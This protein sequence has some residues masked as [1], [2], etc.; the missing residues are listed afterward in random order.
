VKIKLIAVAVAGILLS[1]CNDDNGEV[2]GLSV[3]AFDPAI[4]NMTAKAECDGAPTETSITGYN[5]HAKF[6]TSAPLYAPG[7]CKFT[8]TGGVNAIDVS[9]S[10]SMTGVEYIIPKGMAQTG[11]SVTAS[12]I[13]TLIARELNGAEYTPAAATT[14]LTALGLGALVGSLANDGVDVAKL[15]SDTEA[16]LNNLS[17]KSD[18][19]DYQ[20][21]AATTSSLSEVLLHST[22]TVAE[23]GAATEAFAEETKTDFVPGTPIVITITDTQVDSV[24][25]V[26]G[27]ISTNKPTSVPGK[28]VEPPTTPCDNSSTGG[29]GGTGG[30]NC[31]SI[32]ATSL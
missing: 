30:G 27:D 7:T 6:L 15:L 13:T 9:N 25:A 4:M 16:V 3:Q 23:I 22:A 17:K 2:I 31:G 18:P 29:T 1:G 14:V 5:G 19:S 32:D 12:P 26:P 11:S 8:F 24:V 20:K 28:K 21:L 10:K